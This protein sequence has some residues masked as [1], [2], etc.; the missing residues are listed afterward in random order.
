MCSIK[1]R[2]PNLSLENMSERM[3]A[4]RVFFRVKNRFRMYEKPIIAA[5]I[6]MIELLK[7]NFATK[8][9]TNL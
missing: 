5:E 6:E 3:G 1:I 4:A 8:D 9:Y 2:L 7:V